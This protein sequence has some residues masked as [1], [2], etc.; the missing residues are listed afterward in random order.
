MNAKVA[1]LLQKYP[2]TEW[3]GPAWFSIKSD[4]DGYPNHFVLEH[5]V[6]LDLGNAGHT[7]WDGDDYCKVLPTVLDK[8]PKVAKCIQG[9]IHSHHTMGAFFSGTDDEH[10][11]ESV[12]N[13]FYPS[14]VVASGGKAKFAFAFSYSDQYNMAHVVEIP[15]KDI[16]V[17][18]PKP[19]DEWI[20]ETAKL[21]KPVR[22]ITH[23][24]G[25]GQY[26]GYVGGHQGTFSYDGWGNEYIPHTLH[27]T[28]NL[29]EANGKKKAFY[30][31]L[32]AK[33]EAGTLNLLQLEAKLKEANIDLE[34]NLIGK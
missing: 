25:V 31:K 20:L 16:L 33:Y 23:T 15:E 29:L 6:P 13:T 11:L 32:V 19:K 30:D 12:N 34:G 24:P 9:N 14:L 17:T 18:I 4:E 1:Y 5:F 2:N 10:L 7:E 21:K 3:S 26:N 28:N 27:N 22:V 8:H